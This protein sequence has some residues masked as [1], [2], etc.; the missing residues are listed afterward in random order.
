M[1][2][3]FQPVSKFIETLTDTTE[4]SA[5]LQACEKHAGGN[6][7]IS[8]ME[9]DGDSVRFTDPDEGFDGD[10]PEEN[11][12]TAISQQTD[13]DG[14][15]EEKKELKKKKAGWGL[16]GTPFEQSKGIPKS[17]ENRK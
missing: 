9:T 5:V 6:V 13:Y 1:N 12:P 16:W 4:I 8:H 10:L 2:T 17:P 7:P 11:I 14:L 3:D 15:P